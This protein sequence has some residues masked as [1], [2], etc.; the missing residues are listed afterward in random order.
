MAKPDSAK[1]TALR[2]GGPPWN[3]IVKHSKQMYPSASMCA[4]GLEEIG[5]CRMDNGSGGV[6][7]EVVAYFFFFFVLTT[8]LGTVVPT[9]LRRRMVYLG[10]Y[11]TTYLQGRPAFCPL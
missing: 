4:I 9:Y 8:C 10:R 11:L 5:R 6:C 7:G 2:G 3:G 1:L